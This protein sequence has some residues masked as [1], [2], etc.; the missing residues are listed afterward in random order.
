MSWRAQLLEFTEKAI[1]KYHHTTDD[2]E[3]IGDVYRQRGA[4]TWE[5]FT[6]MKDIEELYGLEYGG[7]LKIVFKDGT[8]RVIMSIGGVLSVT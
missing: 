3:Y 1:R 5:E 4:K 8:S 2:I 6:S 7:G